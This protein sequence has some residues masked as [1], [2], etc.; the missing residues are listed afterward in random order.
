MFVEFMACR[1]KASCSWAH[2]DVCFCVRAYFEALDCA[3]NDNNRGRW[4]LVCEGRF[5]S[6]SAW[7]FDTIELRNLPVLF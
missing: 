4:P 5:G 2:T 3:V 1:F 6:A 7:C